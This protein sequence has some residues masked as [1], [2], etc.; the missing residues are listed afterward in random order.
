MGLQERLKLYMW[1]SLSFHW[2]PIRERISF[3]ATLPGSVHT[4]LAG[5]AFLLALLSAWSTVASD[6]PTAGSLPS[7]GDIIQM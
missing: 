2:P 7:S 5:E 1:L 3:P 6:I 4:S